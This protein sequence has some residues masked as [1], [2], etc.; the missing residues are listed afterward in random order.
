MIRASGEETESVLTYG[1]VDQICRSAAD[2]RLPAT[3]DTEP[4]AV[5]AGALRAELGRRRQD[6]VGDPV[7]VGTLLLDLLDALDGNG[8][9]LVIDDAHWADRPSLQAL[10]FALRRLVADRV[11]AALAVRDTDLLESAGQ[12]ASGAESTEQRG[13][14]AHRDGRDRVVLAGKRTRGARGGIGC[15]APAAR[16]HPGKP[17]AR[18]GVAGG[19][20]AVQLAG[21]G[22]PA[23]AAPVVPA[24]G[25]GPLRGVSGRRPRSGGRRRD[26]RAALHGDAGGGAG[27]RDRPVRALD[28]AT[29]RDLL[30]VVETRSPW[31]LSFPHPLIRSAVYDAIGAARRHSWHLAAVELAAD[32]A[33]ALRHR[34]A[35]AAQPDEELAADLSR[36]AGTLAERLD[37]QGAASHLVTAGRLSPDPRPPSVA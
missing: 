10:T 22:R 30:Q 25:A 6:R 33:A 16:R 35:A 21:G 32:P 2:L 1:V 19:V 20:P 9:V 12:P 37:W 28:E 34:V 4:V 15:G 36:Y 14:A 24:A 29:R 23:A 5:A 11:L 13:A 8:L 26:S 27:R 31:T 3:V 7:L 18:Q 17:V